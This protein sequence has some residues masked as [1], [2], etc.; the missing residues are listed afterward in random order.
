MKGFDVL[1]LGS[2]AVDEV[3]HVERYPRPDT[4]T[5]IVRKERRFGGL[6]GTALATAARLGAVCGYAGRLGTDLNS[7]AVAEALTGIGVDTTHAAVSERF[8]VTNSTIIL[9]PETRNVFSSADGPTGADEHSP[10]SEMIRQSKV[11]L[12]DHHGLPGAIRA[13]SIARDAGVQIVGDFERHDSLLLFSLLTLVNHLILSESFAMAIT[14]ARTVAHSFELL[15]EDCTGNIIITAGAQGCWFL[16]AEAT[17]PRFFPAHSVSA[18]DTLGCGDVFH[19]AYA[20]GLSQG[21][22]P[23]ECVP[24]AS[25]V[26]AIRARKGGNWA[27]LPTLAEVN[28]LQPG[29]APYPPA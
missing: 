1:G 9:S 16:G 11:I 3:I 27:A 19:G 29:A 14:E 26:A 5:R 22:T 7:R 4:K 8:S 6:T 24:L 23:A 21:R 12:V 13:A 28:A 25:Q 17:Q 10:N 20:F 2:L 18:S 15:R